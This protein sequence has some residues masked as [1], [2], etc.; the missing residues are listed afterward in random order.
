MGV[1]ELITGI[2]VVLVGLAFVAYLEVKCRA[3]EE[4]YKD[5]P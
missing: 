1:S 5:E 4:D 3:Q 2:I